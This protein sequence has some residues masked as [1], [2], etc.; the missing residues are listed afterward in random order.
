MQIFIFV[1]KSISRRLRNSL[2]F[3][4]GQRCCGYRR[5]IKAVHE[6]ALFKRTNI[7]AD[8]P[9]VKN[10]QIR[11]NNARF[12]LKTRIIQNVIC[13]SFRTHTLIRLKVKPLCLVHFGI[14]GISRV[15]ILGN[16]NLADF[17]GVFGYF[18]AELGKK[19]NSFRRR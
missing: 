19:R 16:D 18:P 3:G 13:P 5:K 6:A 7:S 8:Y 17:N 12:V 14:F 2:C 10:Q 15:K 9:A 11:L 4:S 1:E